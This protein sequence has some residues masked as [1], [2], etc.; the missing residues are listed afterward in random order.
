MGRLDKSHKP[1][2]IHDVFNIQHKML[3]S[4]QIKTKINSMRKT[5]DLYFDSIIAQNNCSVISNYVL[6]GIYVLL[7]NLI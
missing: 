5:I 2:K 3:I 7:N 4:H 1:Y 6:R